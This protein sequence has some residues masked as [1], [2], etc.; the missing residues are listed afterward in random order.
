MADICLGEDSDELT[1]PSVV[2][3]ATLM[4]VFYL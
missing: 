4:S 3:Y 1:I 2:G